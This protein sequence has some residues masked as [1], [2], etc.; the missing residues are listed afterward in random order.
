MVIVNQLMIRH[1]GLTEQV[2]L[3]HR[4]VLHRILPHLIANDLRG[5]AYH[6]GKI[7][8]FRVIE[9]ITKTPLN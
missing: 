6:R 1:F 4:L 9:A 8:A 3:C 7:M 2:V 5:H